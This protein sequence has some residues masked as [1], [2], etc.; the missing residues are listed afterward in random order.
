M[1]SFTSISFYKQ[2]LENPAEVVLSLVTFSVVQSRKTQNGSKLTWPESIAVFPGLAEEEMS[3]CENLI[4]IRNQPDRN[5]HQTGHQVSSGKRTFYTPRRQLTQNW[6]NEAP[7]ILSTCVKTATR[8]EGESENI[9]LTPKNENEVSVRV[10]GRR[11][12]GRKQQRRS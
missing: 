9:W 12:S 10:W 1:S 4:L 5:F 8:K 3:V 6:L 2:L 11:A 7:W